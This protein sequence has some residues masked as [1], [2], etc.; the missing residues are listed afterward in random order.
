VTN[1]EKPV[2]IPRGILE[3]LVPGGAHHLALELVGDRLSVPG[4]EV[5]H[6]VD[7]LSVVLRRDLANARREAAVDV[8][9][10][11]R[12]PGVATGPRAL[13]GAKTEGP[14]EDIERLANLLRVRI[15]AEVHDPAAVPLAREHH[16]RVFVLQ[17]HSD[18]GKR[19]V[20]A[21]ADVERRPM[22]LDEA[23]L[24]MKGLRLRA[25]DDR[26]HVRDSLDELGRAQT[27][28]PATLE[29]APHARP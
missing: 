10:E 23:L 14:V 6:P 28:V 26:L 8:V 29:V 24:E 7:D 16:A 22:P 2:A 5:D 3:A 21:E 17:R 1:R 20:V 19:L 15:R 18:V 12:D 9:I 4:E 11:A 25:G 27:A 13:A